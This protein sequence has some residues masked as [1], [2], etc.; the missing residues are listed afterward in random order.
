MVEWLHKRKNMRFYLS[1]LAFL[2]AGKHIFTTFA[3][4]FNK[5]KE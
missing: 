1:F 3:A 4:E 5:D 2:L